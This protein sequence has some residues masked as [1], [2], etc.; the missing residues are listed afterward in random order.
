MTAAQHKT[1]I[2][3]AAGV[4]DDPETFFAKE[5]ADIF[6]K[7]ESLMDLKVMMNRVWI[8]NWV[9]PESRDLGGGKRIYLTDNSRAEDVYQGCSGLIIK[10]GP[11]AFKSDADTNFPDPVPQVGDWV[12]F[13]RQ[14][15]G[16]RFKHN[17][18]DCVMLEEERP[19]KGILSRPDVVE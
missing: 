4:I 10:M 14:N 19:I 15:G 6:A 1:P 9:R 16:M 18:V 2:I 11:L 12:L 5:K 8:A 3:T 7:L 17:G 13:K